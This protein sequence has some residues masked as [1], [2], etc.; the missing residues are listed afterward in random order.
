MKLNV[1]RLSTSIKFKSSFL[2]TAPDIWLN[3]C[4]LE[5]P[6]NLQQETDRRS[7]VTEW[8]CVLPSSF[9]DA[10]QTGIELLEDLCRMK[11]PSYD[12]D[13]GIPQKTAN[14]FADV[15]WG[16]MHQ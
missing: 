15:R 8:Q 10:K 4:L 9:Y 12:P 3:H 14:L 16:V 13:S 2:K 6:I 5:R 11:C 1:I 7:V